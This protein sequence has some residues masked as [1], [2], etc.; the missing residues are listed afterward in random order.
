MSASPSLPVL[1]FA[2]P[3]LGPS[4]TAQ[5]AELRAVCKALELAPGRSCV[6]S[7]SAS[8][9]Q[10]IG[11]LIAGKQ[12]LPPLH[13]DLWTYLCRHGTSLVSVRWIKAHLPTPSAAQGLGFSSE[14]WEGNQVAD[15]L[16]C[17]GAATHPCR[18]AVECQYN[19]NLQ[20]V[21][22]TQRH[23]LNTWTGLQETRAYHEH[24]LQRARR[25]E[26]H[27]RQAGVAS[28]FR[29]TSQQCPSARSPRRHHSITHTTDF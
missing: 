29:R 15:R 24:L 21:A 6:V 27:P 1:D 3:L 26:E 23:M 2:G 20:L 14:D 12:H 28:R 10:G 16:A 5:R 19:L 13:R 22:A 11:Q 8:V 25:R 18:P 4:Q 7:D 17:A 9:V